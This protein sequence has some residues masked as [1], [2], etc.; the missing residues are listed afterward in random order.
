MCA[1]YSYLKLKKRFSKF[2]FQKFFQ[3]FFKK[4]FFSKFSFSN[5]FSEK[6]GF[7]PEISFDFVVQKSFLTK[8]FFVVAE[9]NLR[10]GVHCILVLIKLPR[11]CRGL[12]LLYPSGGL[13]SYKPRQVYN[14]PRASNLSQQKQKRFWSKMIFEQQNQKKKKSRKKTFFQN[15]IGKK[16]CEKIFLKKI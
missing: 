9:I 16:I 2:F 11:N 7:L 8:F 12:S 4:M 6:K 14:G 5:F 10:P 15:K 3:I 13:T 1:R